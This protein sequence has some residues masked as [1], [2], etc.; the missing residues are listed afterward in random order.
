[1][2]LLH[3]GDSELMGTEPEEMRASFYICFECRFVG[4]VGVGPVAIPEVALTR[5]AMERREESVNQWREQR[6][7]DK[8]LCPNCK[9]DPEENGCY[10][11]DGDCEWFDAVR[12]TV[13]QLVAAV[14][15]EGDEE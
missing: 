10:P 15:G 14:V 7:L 13:G 4:Q 3:P 5:K 12:P 9:M 11:D 1:M 2:F 8:D 6:A